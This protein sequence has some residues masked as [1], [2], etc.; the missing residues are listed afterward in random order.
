MRP[1]FSPV[2]VGIPSAAVRPPIN[3]VADPFIRFGD[4]AEP[5]DIAMK[6]RDFFGLDDHRLVDAPMLAPRL[7]Q[8]I[9]HLIVGQILRPKTFGFESNE[10]IG[11]P[12]STEPIYNC[13]T[14]RTKFG[15]A[16]DIIGKMSML[17]PELSEVIQDRII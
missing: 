17:S 1:R 15:R 2:F 5:F 14:A 8:R 13:I 11:G 6:G 3:L 9:E 4:R 7:P 12:H 16:D 10:P